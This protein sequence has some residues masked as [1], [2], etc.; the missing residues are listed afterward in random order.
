MKWS[1][2]EEAVQRIR[3][4]PG[5]LPRSGLTLGPDGRAT[6]ILVAAAEPAGTFDR[7]AVA[8][9][10]AARYEPLPK[11]VPQVTRPAKQRVTFKLSN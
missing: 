7:A 10:Q 11:S 2:T 5:L 9:L 3:P 1:L 6:G 8:A 4:L